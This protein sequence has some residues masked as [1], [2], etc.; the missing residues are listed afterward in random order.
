MRKAHLFVWRAWANA[1]WVESK[2]SSLMNLRRLTAPWEKPGDPHW[3]LITCI[4][5]SNILHLKLILLINGKY[6]YT[7]HHQNIHGSNLELFI[8]LKNLYILHKVVVIF[9][10]LFKHL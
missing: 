5:P 10:K 3:C 9:N 2:T 6:H 8:F 1:C 7:I 4:D